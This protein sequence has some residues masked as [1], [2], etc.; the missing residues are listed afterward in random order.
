MTSTLPRPAT[1]TQRV[2]PR[3]GG[4]LRRDQR[5]WLSTAAVFAA[6]MLTS[7]N[8]HSVLFGWTWLNPLA[9]TV[10][11]VLL[12]MG[13]ARSARLPAALVPV[14]G[15][16]AL[17]GALVWQYFPGQSVF[18]IF[19]GEGAAGRLTVLLNHAENTVV[20]QVAPVLPGT[21][22]FLVVCAAMGLISILTDTLA[23]TL[24][25]PATSGLALLAILVVPAVVRPQ[26]VGVPGFVAAVVGF[27]ILLGCSQWRDSQA[28]GASRD[29]SGGRLARGLSIGAAALA[30]TIL[31]PLAIP[32]F[33][34]GLFPQGARVNLWGTATGLNPV[35]TLG[36][37]LRNP[38]GFGR[39]TYA[40]NSPE[41]LYLRAVTL[42]DF[43]GER[44]EPDQRHSI[45]QPGV[46]EMGTDEVRAAIDD[47]VVTTTRITTD[48]FTSPWLLAPYAPVGFSN[49]AG[50]WS[51]DPLNHSI[52]ATD[53]G[54][55]AQQEYVVRSA[56]PALTRTRLQAVGPVAE[57]AVDAQFLSLP[58]T[59]PAIIEQTATLLTEDIVNP[60]EQAL[61]IQNYLR[62]P[63]FTYSV[64]APVEGGYDGNSLDV[65]ARFLESKSG[66]CV[67]Y[68]GAMAVMARV[69]GI[70]SRVAVG[71]APGTPTGETVSGPDGVELT[72]FTVTSLDA[73][74]WPELYFDDLGWVKFEPTPSR[75]VVPEY[76]QTAFAPGA[77]AANP[78]NLDPG[79]NPLT[80]PGT[81]GTPGQA[82][83]DPQTE[84]ETAERARETSTL[85]MGVLVGGVLLLFVPLLLRTLRRQRRRRRF[86]GAA[87]DGAAAALAWAEVVDLAA[88]YG[89]PALPTDTPRTFAA[90]LSTTTGIGGAAGSALVRLRTAYEAAQYAD[91][92]SL[93]VVAEGAPS[94]ATGRGGGPMVPWTG[95]APGR[96]VPLGW[97]DVQAIA[98]ALRD[99][100]GR[101]AR[102]R[103]L[104]LPRS[105]SGDA[106]G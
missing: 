18:G 42:E 26:S 11:A 41:A 69:A 92:A 64:D 81:T 60:Y 36:N 84:A 101:A 90:R 102:I 65:V 49:L 46:E 6:V 106:R 31:V 7:L 83:E 61:A 68:A 33:N 27:L 76:A 94:P 1:P 93:V 88:D 4:R 16:V 20:S 75:G 30:V 53:N 70:P 37:D 32:G 79:G 43:D 34:V 8:L 77:P 98:G 50:R 87:G 29:A 96:A 35:V 66:Y 51:W 24:R 72:E 91:P 78:D 74:A 55:T 28:T 85:V 86:T 71:Y 104:L 58:D 25:M 89:H 21:G 95:T 47:G 12:V 5:H 103:A 3:S 23:T 17:V 14:A 82:A 97:D 44:W 100:S 99:S 10:G 48:T 57:G 39:I 2:E 38:T 56:G 62:G 15:L 52:I 40:T 59:T 54:S 9:F 45:R 73:H 13:A 67:H 22:I 63:S 105:L 19:P 80:D